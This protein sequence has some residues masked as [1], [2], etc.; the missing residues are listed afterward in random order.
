M[1]IWHHIGINPKPLLEA[2][3]ESLGVNLTRRALPGGHYT[4][5][6]DADELDPLWSMI[7]PVI[8]YESKVDIYET[9]FT[10]E[11]ILAAEW[12]R[13][14]PTFERGYPQPKGIW[15][16]EPNNLIQKCPV[17]GAGYSQ[18]AP[19]RLSQ[20]PRMGQHDFLCLYWTYT[21]TFCTKRVIQQLREHDLK[22]YDIWDAVL[23]RTGAPSAVVSQLVPTQLTSNGL[24]KVDQMK[25]VTCD[26]C[27]ITKYA[28]HN[29]GYMQYS[30][31]AL[32][33]GV[34]MLYTSEWFGSGGAAFREV[35]VSNRFARLS[36]EQAWQGIAMKPLKLV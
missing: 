8:R 15:Q 23:H 17:C 20:E 6:F 28:Y 27:G 3:L 22:G 14:R 29:K 2:R 7:E 12:V 25:S 18:V 19:Y 30:R 1:E 26:R 9:L 36:L 16:F 21:T 24:A 32:R 34:D 35:L 33:D 31:N 10:R 4:I 11:E 5:T 13:L